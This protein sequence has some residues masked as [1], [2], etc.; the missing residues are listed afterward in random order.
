MDEPEDSGLDRRSFLAGAATG[1][2]ALLAQQA[3]VAGAQEV[4]SG[5]GPANG[6]TRPASDYMVDIFKSLDFEYMFS[7]CAS[8]FMG[9]HESILNYAGN[10]NPESITCTHEEISVAMANGYAKIE[11]KPVLV[12]AHSTVGAQHAA[13]AVYDAWCDR[14]P[15]YLV[16]GN[17][18]DAEHR[19]GEV[20]WVH[21]A[22]DPGALLRDMTK[23][24]DNPASLAHFAESAVRAYKI[25]MTPP[26]GPVAVVV[27]DH[28]QEQN[29]PADLR[30]PRVAV[31]APPAGDSGAVAEAARL[32]VAA[33][34]P[35]ILASRVARTPAGLKLMVELAETLQA[36]VVDSRHRLNFPN[37]HPLSGGS[38]GEADVI[39]ALEHGDISNAVRQ[40]RERNAK[41]I[42]LSSTHLFQRSNYQDVMRYAEVDLAIAAD[43]EATL[44]ALI[45]EIRRLTTDVR[46]EAFRRRGE[47]VAAANRQTYERARGE[48]ANGWDASP[49][50]TAR[51]AMELW[52]QLKNEDWSYVTG[53][54]NWPLRLW[55]FEQHHQYIGRAGGEG[56][57]Y[58]APASVGAALANKK[59]G[60]I[61]VAIQP[62]GDLMVAPG[63]LW[64]AARYQIP[65]LV[66][67]QNNRA[68]HQEVMWFQRAALQRQRSLELTQVGFG[69]GNPDID[70]A[71]LAESMGVASSGPITDPKDLAAAIR[72]GL[73][74]VKGGEPYLIDVVTQPR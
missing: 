23:W 17:T 1:A 31:P 66:V 26:M 46:R 64:T 14:V 54:V 34:N 15:I 22:Q 9:I 47:R 67:M 33:E 49:V 39:L 4:A 50:S 73:A 63:A 70:F 74:V 59:H 69:L 19:R 61:S 72:R 52:A 51:L 8:S 56:V 7:M 36:G 18:Q 35:V 55:T 48:A 58:F 32:L 2:A 68:Y 38:P 20:Y 57:G 12:C 62:D 16:L 45:E 25:A 30:V 21:S 27:D 60:R 40:A 42:S 44:P 10:R 6:G 53:W 41:V 28:M 3:S 11:G 5:Q 65:L 37:R 43:A 24:D 29:V 13:M 71:K